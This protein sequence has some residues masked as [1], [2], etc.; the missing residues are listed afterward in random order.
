MLDWFS[1]GGKSTRVSAMAVGLYSRNGNKSGFTSLLRECGA[2]AEENRGVGGG[3]ILKTICG[4]GSEGRGAA[5]SRRRRRRCLPRRWCRGSG[6]RAAWECRGAAR[7]RRRRRGTSESGGSR[8]SPPRRRGSGR[9]SSTPPPGRRKPFGLAPLL[10]LSA[11]A[12]FSP[13]PPRSAEGLRAPLLLP[14]LGGSKVL[15]W[16]EVETRN[17][18]RRLFVWPSLSS[19]TGPF[20]PSLNLFGRPSLSL[21]L[22][23][24]NGHH[25]GRSSSGR[26]NCFSCRKTP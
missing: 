23:V 4:G 16:M 3:G 10:L 22:E 15:I 1:R 20:E 18:K 11:C 24:A 25:L 26:V 7:G 12:P 5:G 6:G 2:G 19:F 9:R 17:R 8:R 14:W 21:S 13:F